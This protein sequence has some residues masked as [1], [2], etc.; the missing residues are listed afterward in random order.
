[1][2]IVIAG[3]AH[4]KDQPGKTYI[5]EV[6]QLSRDPE[7]WKHVVFVEDY[8]MKV[9]ARAGAGRRR[10][11]QHSAARRRGLRHQRDESRRST[12]C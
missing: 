2:Q 6:V 7:L 10:V 11:A 1:M 5:R 4:P 9:G 12:E 3:K 8:D